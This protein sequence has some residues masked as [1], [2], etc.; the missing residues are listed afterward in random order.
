MI[1]RQGWWGYKDLGRAIDRDIQHIY[2]FDGNCHFLYLGQRFTWDAAKASAN[3]A[4]HGIRF[5]TAC[6]VFFDPFLATEDAT[7]S[8]EQREAV[9]GLTE[10]WSLLFVMHTVRD[11]K[12][13]RIISARPATAH[14]R[15]R[16]EDGE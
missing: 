6:Q 3:A 13:I 11:E 5:E 12:T 15:K 7:A 10:D 1:V 14:E 8:S 2:D 9:I 16:Y 4:K